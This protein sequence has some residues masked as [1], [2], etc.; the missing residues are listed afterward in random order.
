MFAMRGGKT[1]IIKRGRATSNP[2]PSP[3]TIPRYWGHYGDS[4]TAGREAEATA[5]NPKECFKRMWEA[6]GF[7]SILG[8]DTS[9]NAG[10]SGRSLAGTLT[11]L[12][13]RPAFAGTA[14]IHIQESG[15]Q[16]NDGQRTASEWGATFQQGWIDVET[17]HPG[18]FKSYETAHSFS[19]ARKAQAYRN[20]DAYNTELRSRV[21]TLA[22][23]GIDVKIVETEYYIDFM[24]A[25][26]GYDTVCFPDSDIN[27]YHYQGIG[28]FTIAL[29]M[30]KRFNY[31]VTTLDHSTI[32][33]NAS[34]K[35]TAVSIVANN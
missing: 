27:A 16:N 21:T 34:H 35:S 20:W 30:F 11:Y 25:A 26:L 31:D 2:P 4:Q 15:D 8:N 14:W 13:G 17:K 1:A 23:L 6:E 28:N 19:P 3:L 24:I 32:N 9:T 18:C 5:K 22:G 33:L 10:V 12:Q 7:S 29:A